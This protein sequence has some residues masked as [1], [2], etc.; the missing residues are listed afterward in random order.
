MVLLSSFLVL[1]VL[2]SKFGQD[3][4][5]SVDYALCRV[6]HLGCTSTIGEEGRLCCQGQALRPIWMEAVGK[7]SSSKQTSKQPNEVSCA[8][9]IVL[10][11]SNIELRIGLTQKNFGELEKQLFEVSDPDHE[12]YGN[13]L[14]AEEVHELIAPAEHAV[15]SVHDWLEENN[16]RLDQV[17][18][19]QA[20][21]WL[22]IDLPVSEVESLLDTEYHV[23]ENEVSV[24]ANEGEIVC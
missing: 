8:H 23:Y 9:A 4:E 22:V 14:S 13:H 10:Q 16:V 5:P 2:L 24:E 6:C 19:S 20:R 18:Y 17:K 11:D 21:D 1:L 12:N 3:E 15:N 7:S